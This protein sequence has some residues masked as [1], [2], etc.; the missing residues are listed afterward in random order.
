MVELHGMMRWYVGKMHPERVR[1]LQ[2]TMTAVL[3]YLEQYV[4]EDVQRDFLQQLR[5]GL[6]EATK[7][8]S[9]PLFK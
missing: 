8:G 9:K 4:K 5:K 7:E 3:R 1:N 6:D 2:D